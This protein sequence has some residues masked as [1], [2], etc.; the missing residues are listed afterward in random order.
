MTMLT[1]H[2]K[3][4]LSAL[5][6]EEMIASQRFIAAYMRLDREIPGKPDSAGRIRDYRCQFKCEMEIAREHMRI[7]KRKCEAYLQEINGGQDARQ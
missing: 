6:F 3:F 5:Q 4:M 2:Q 1:P 7:A